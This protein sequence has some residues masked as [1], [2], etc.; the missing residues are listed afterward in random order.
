MRDSFLQING[1]ANKANGQEIFIL[2]SL[3][4]YYTAC[5][6]KNANRKDHALFHEGIRFI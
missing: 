5:V 1:E 4:A 3:F 6:I 2:K